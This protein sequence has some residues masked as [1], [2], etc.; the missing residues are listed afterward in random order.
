MK[1]LE[2]NPS[3]RLREAALE[4]DV[5]SLSSISTI[6]NSPRIRTN[7]DLP[8]ERNSNLNRDSGYH[9]NELVLPASTTRSG[10]SEHTS[11][12]LSSSKSHARLKEDEYYG[13][14]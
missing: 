12:Y 4:S 11:V 2:E 13:N 9:G 8:P 7:V 14:E 10:P 6:R 3:P 1:K 5:F